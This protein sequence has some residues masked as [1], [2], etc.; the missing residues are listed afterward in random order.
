MIC[1]RLGRECLVP[2]LKVIYLSS[3]DS[4]PWRISLHKYLMFSFFFRCFLKVTRSFARELLNCVQQL[5]SFWV[6]LFFSTFIKWV[7]A[8]LLASSLNFIINFAI[9]QARNFLHSQTFYGFR[10]VN[11]LFHFGFNASH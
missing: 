1:V 4:P 7:H 6:A 5:I 11:P 3:S 2:P 10:L 9:Y 8:L